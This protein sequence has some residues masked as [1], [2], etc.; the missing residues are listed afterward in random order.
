[1]IRLKMNKELNDTMEVFGLGRIFAEPD[2]VTISLGV[3]TIH[4]E[5]RI[6]QEENAVRMEQVIRV[7]TS[8]GI[9]Q[10]D[11]QTEYYN[12]ERRYEYVE[13]RQIDKGMLR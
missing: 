10:E 13:G 3:E 1:M 2:M 12:I 7:I 5:L 9:A 8:M 11:I 4:P 6:A